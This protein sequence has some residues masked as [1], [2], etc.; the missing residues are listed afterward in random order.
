MDNI[1]ATSSLT[2]SASVEQVVFHRNIA[3]IDLALKCVESIS[4]NSKRNE[5]AIH[6]FFKYVIPMLEKN[7][8]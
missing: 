2:A 1:T 6:L 7:N 4:D 5:L 3:L 8:G